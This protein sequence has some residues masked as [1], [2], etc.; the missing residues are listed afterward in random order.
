MTKSVIYI[1]LFFV[2]ITISCKKDNPDDEDLSES[3]DTTLHEDPHDYLW[4]DESVN[5]IEL[6]GSTATTE[7]QGVL[8]NG[9]LVIINSAGNY[10]LTG[11]LQGAVIISTDTSSLIRLILDGAVIE[12]STG[13][14]ILIESSKKTIINLVENTENLLTD[15]TS[16]I[17]QGAEVNAAFYSKSN[18]TIFG[19]G[20]LVVKGNFEDGITSKDGLILKSG[21]ISIEAVDDGL[22]GK[23]YIVIMDGKLILNTGGNGIVSD[24]TASI[25]TGFI[26]IESGNTIVTS[27]GDGIAANSSVISTSGSINISSGG[28]SS[29]IPST[30]KSTKGIK[31]LLK[32]E[33]AFI[34][35]IINSSD[36]GIHSNG[37]IKIKAGNYSVSTAD[38]AIHAD[39]EIIIDNG[40]VSVPKSKEGFESKT[41]IINDGTLN[42]T[43][44]DDTFN[45]TAGTATEEDDHS[46]VYFNGGYTVLH[47]VSGDGLDSNGSIQLNDGTVIIQGPSNEPEVAID[48][49]GIF[50][51][52]GGF[53]IASGTG[54]NMTQAP[55]NTSIQHSVIINFQSAYNTST[56]FHIS[57]SEGKGIVTF[58]PERKF[59]SII[60]SSSQLKDQGIY[61]IY[62]GGSSSGNFTDGLNN[63]GNYEPG[64][65]NHQFK[66]E[67]MVTLLNNI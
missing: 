23:D 10:R 63:E 38:D 67:S 20:S 39:T 57:D 11:E 66:V 45:A 24:N 34:D 8:I 9:N 18:L 56:L 62:T 33:L 58:K 2:A 26:R 22:R 3:A 21:N 54:S 49:N 17:G 32:V 61:Y 53:L 44:S 55:G 14:A 19:E 52:N 37:A 48:Y 25:Y 5:T 16:Y 41:I 27:L 1:L 6:L 13:P 43:S 64:N 60:F 47:A 15:G 31:G 40:T 4:S 46:Y 29:I 51:I 28:G 12:N 30:D 50:N 7:A 65:L 42:I 36:D 35:C 59:Q